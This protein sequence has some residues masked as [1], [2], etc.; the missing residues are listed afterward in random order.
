MNR[1]TNP[2][3]SRAIRQLCPEGQRWIWLRELD[4]EQRIVR[5][6]YE[7]FK[8]DGL[9]GQHK[10][11]VK[12][13]QGQHTIFHLTTSELS[14]MLGVKPKNKPKPKSS[15]TDDFWATVETVKPSRNGHKARK[16]NVVDSLFDDDEEEDIDED[17]LELAHYLIK[18]KKRKANINALFK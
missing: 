6:N 8:A 16:V 3:D 11:L 15:P 7:P 18:G 14:K 2:R 17:F 12:R 13:K 9:V 10:K 5:S 4:G 1:K